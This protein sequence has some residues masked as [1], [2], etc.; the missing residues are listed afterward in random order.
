MVGYSS[1]NATFVN[2]IVVSSSGP[3]IKPGD[4]GS[5]LVTDPGR[6]PVGL[7]F[8]GDSS[9]TT[10]IAN[11]ITDVLGGFSSLGITIDGN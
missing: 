5:L 8:A 4:S 11:T 7:L 2:Q 10:A 6:S 3:F 1:G 9:G